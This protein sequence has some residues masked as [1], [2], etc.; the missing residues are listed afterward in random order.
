MA[1]LPAEKDETWATAETPR[2]GSAQIPEEAPSGEEDYEEWKARAGCGGGRGERG[3]PAR[4]RAPSLPAGRARPRRPETG[5]ARGSPRRSCALPARRRVAAPLAGACGGVARG[6][7]AKC[8]SGL[9][10]SA[11]CGCL[12]RAQRRYPSVLDSW[13]EFEA[14]T[15]GKRIAVFSDYDGTRRLRTRGMRFCG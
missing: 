8:D 1:A 9:Q 3:A 11:D 6:S 7:I 13:E 14:L 15:E 2:P 12:P 10:A 5:A 4:Q